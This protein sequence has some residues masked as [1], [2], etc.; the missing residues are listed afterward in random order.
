[1]PV[2]IYWTLVKNSPGL[3]DEPERFLSPAELEKLDSFRFQKRRTDWLLGRWTAKGLLRGV[4]DYARFRPDRIEVQSAPGGAPR[5]RLPDGV[6]FPG[7]LSISHRDQLAFCALSLAS[8]ASTG[9]HAGPRLGADLEKVE[10]RSEAFLADY[11]T[12]A[13]QAWIRGQPGELRDCAAALAWSAKEAMLKA[14]EVGMGWDTRWVEVR[15][16]EGLAD[17]GQEGWK[18]MQVSSAGR[19]EHPWAAWWRRGGEYVMTVAAFGGS[20]SFRLVEIQQD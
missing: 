12:P 13:E 7:C 20:G 6:P 10:P 5:L 4:Q 14:L 17:A 3:L 16:A 9:P 2:T 18:S 15:Q 19:E 8:Q 1:M 11:F